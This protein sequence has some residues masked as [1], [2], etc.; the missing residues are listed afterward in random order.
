MP[1]LSPKAGRRIEERKALETNS[2]ERKTAV[3]F[4]A[5]SNKI[6]ILFKPCY[7]EQGKEQND[8]VLNEE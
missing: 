6:V 5:E 7:T 8:M 4:F 2:S 1:E 3:C